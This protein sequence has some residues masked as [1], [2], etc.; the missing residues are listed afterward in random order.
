MFLYHHPHRHGERPGR[1]RFDAGRVITYGK[2]V[3]PD[4]VQAQMWFNLAA[5]RHNSDKKENEICGMLSTAGLMPEEV[6][7]A[8]VIRIETNA[9]K[10]DCP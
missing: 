5:S 1:G 3:P 10:K 2:G 6:V 4:G 7:P 8:L 9:G